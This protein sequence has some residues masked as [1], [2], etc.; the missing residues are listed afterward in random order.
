[1]LPQ[2]LKI[3]S[4]FF[5]S[6]CTSHACTPVVERAEG[7]LT[8]AEEETEAEEE[9]TTETTEEGDEANRCKPPA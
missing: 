2:L 4:V 7:N 6:V 5:P 8:A 3:D 1:M 9:E